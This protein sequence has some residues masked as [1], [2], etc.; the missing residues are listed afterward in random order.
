VFFGGRGNSLRKEARADF[1]CEG[2]NVPTIKGSRERTLDAHEKGASLH[3]SQRR[4][5]LVEESYRRANLH[6]HRLLGQSQE[7]EGGQAIDRERLTRSI[8]L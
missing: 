7:S 8:P 2:L 1:M 5:L 6:A 3:A 4:G